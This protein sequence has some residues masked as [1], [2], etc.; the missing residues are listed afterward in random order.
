MALHEDDMRGLDAGDESFQMHCRRQEG[1]GLL[2]QS[3]AQ[4]GCEPRV[5][6][7]VG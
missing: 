6:P 7:W 4:D 1:A 3:M 5:P 2:R